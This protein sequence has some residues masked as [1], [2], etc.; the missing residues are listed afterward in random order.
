MRLCVEMLGFL[1]Q[2][3]RDDRGEDAGDRE[4]FEKFRS[5]LMRKNLIV[6]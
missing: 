5:T 2:L 4:R 1:L 6:W 3:T